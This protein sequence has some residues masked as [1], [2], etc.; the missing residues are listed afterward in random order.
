LRVKLGV[1]KTLQT[2][3][4]SFPES[5]DLRQM[6]GNSS[7]DQSIGETVQDHRG[8]TDQTTHQDTS[9][10][11]NDD[12]TTPAVNSDLISFADD[13]TATTSQ[14]CLLLFVKK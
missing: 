10:L 1:L 6:G 11:S 7:R 5:N 3:E 14:V 4:H 8:G 13:F 9:F 12:A 2:F